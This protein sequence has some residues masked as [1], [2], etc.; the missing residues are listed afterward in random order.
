MNPLTDRAVEPLSRQAS[1]YVGSPLYRVIPEHAAAWLALGLLLLGVLILRRRSDRGR[2]SVIVAG[3]RTLASDK[4]LLAWLIASS[5]AI[6]TGLALGNKLDIYAAGFAI[7]SALLFVVARRLVLGQRWRRWAALVLA[8]SILGFVASSMSGVAPDQVSLVT[9]LI[10]I[11]ALA[12]VLTPAHPSRIRQFGASTAVVTLLTLTAIGSWAGAFSAGAGGHHLGEVPEP[13]IL[14][15][16]GEDRDPTPGEAQAAD[17]LYAAT[18]A[19]TALWQDTAQ[20]AVDGYAVE[21]ISG[22]EF[23]ADNQTYLNDGMTLDPTRPESLIYAEGPDGP[24]LVGVLYQMSGIGVPGP[25]VGGPLTVWHAHDNV[26]FSLTPPA[27]A[28]LVSP[29]GMCPVGSL[30]IPITNEMLHIWTV[31]G[32]PEP[33]G[34]LDDEWLDNYIDNL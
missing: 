19:A 1:D 17:D 9:K 24:I 2:P 16:I 25:S 3:Y 34:D 30:A 33:F 6:H 26:C 14:L 4:R 21:G 28:G 20:A 29:L 12:L 7:D 23:H 8:G 18:V 5:A 13:G 22:R 27:L 31:P 11:A 32:I 10:E 15:P